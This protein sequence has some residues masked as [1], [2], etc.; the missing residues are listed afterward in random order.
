M[1][2]SVRAALREHCFGPPTAEV[3]LLV[4]ELGSRAG[5]MGAA[6]LLEL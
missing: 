3:P 6:S 2:L 4:S 1:E 5:V